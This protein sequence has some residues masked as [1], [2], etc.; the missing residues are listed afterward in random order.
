MEACYRPTTETPDRRCATCA[1]AVLPRAV[2]S[3]CHDQD[4][5]RSWLG[6][7]G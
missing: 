5:L 4:W 7:L 3:P 1:R 6:L 2:A